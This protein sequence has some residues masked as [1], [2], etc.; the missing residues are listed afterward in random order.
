MET[1]QARS[2]LPSGSETLSKSLVLPEP[3]FPHL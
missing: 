2:L 1:P 3:Q